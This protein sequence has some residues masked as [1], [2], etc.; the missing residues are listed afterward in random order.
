VITPRLAWVLPEPIADP[1]AFDGFGAPVATLLARRGI[2]DAEQLR[3]F[4]AAGIDELPPISV[5]ADADRALARI[6]QA[7]ETGE[8]IAIWGD[9]DADGMSAVAVWIV[10]LRR[11][12]IEPDRYVP[13]RLAEG[14]GLSARGIEA[15]AARGVR[16]IITCD[17]GVGNAAEIAGA[18]RLGIDVVVTDHHLPPAELPPAAAVVDPHRL[19]CPYPDPDLT[20]AGLAFRLAGELLRR[21]SVPTTDL[22]ALAAIGTVADVAPMTGESRAIVRLGLAELAATDRAGLRALLRRAVADPDAPTGRELAFTIA[23]R[24]NAAGRIDEAELAIALLVEEDPQRA[25]ELAEQLEAV[26]RRRRELSAAA[27]EEARRLVD[28][29]EA[30]SP[31]AIR[32]DGWAPGII[33]LVAGRLADLLAR[34][35]AIATLVGDELRGS[36]RAPLDFHVARA[37]DACAVHLTKLGGH[38]AAGGFSALPAAW[39]EF[40]TAFS[41]LARPYPNGTAPLRAADSLAVDLVLPA[42]RLGWPLQAELDRL[43]PYGPGHAEP[44][45]AVTGLRVG[46]ARRVGDGEAHLLL[47]MRRGHETLD[48][49]AFGMPPDRPLPAPE[50]LV[51]LVGTLEA[52]RFE[53]QPR[54]R[55]R[56]LDYADAE[57]SPLL[58]R[59]ARPAAAELRVAPIGAG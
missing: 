5:M 45:L 47:R 58:A 4:L 29:E 2:R 13:S 57:A 53:G 16:L 28:G 23:P 22:A 50:T 56:V 12:G 40:A 46:E 20:G 11:L 21:R 15:L 1:P 17:C 36:V 9:Y 48:A 6:D 14:Y 24:V 26:H 38:A 31:L 41:S 43:A 3:R 51:D 34:P 37:L 25:D 42:A 39:D 19:D 8:R 59:R 35:V 33:G 7:L 52:D 55:L 32:N 18:R 30:T 54:L 44:I 27:I 10:A 49:I